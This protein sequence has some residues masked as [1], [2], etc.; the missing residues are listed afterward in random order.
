MHVSLICTILVALSS[1]QQDVDVPS[2]LLDEPLIETI[3][4]GP[5]EAE[6]PAGM[7]DVIETISPAEPGE[8]VI[9]VGFDLDYI[10]TI[11]ES[12]TPFVPFDERRERFVFSAC[13]LEPNPA[14]FDGLVDISGRIILAQSPYG[15]PV[16]VRANVGGMPHPASKYAFSINERGWDSLDC[17]SSGAHW[18]PQ[19]TDHGV[20]QSSESHVGDLRQ[21]TTDLRGSVK[22]FQRASRPMLRGPQSIEGKAMAIYAQPDDLGTSGT[23]ESKMNGNAGEIIACCNIVRVANLDE[24]IDAQTT[25]EQ[26]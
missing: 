1:A 11:A 3:S 26:I 22:F 17:A 21:L 5:S 16:Y 23:T 18:N 15:G 14:Y 6:V 12:T 20:T 8:V 24:Y 19:G 4:E 9:P 13:E 7:E 2:F 25:S 10:E